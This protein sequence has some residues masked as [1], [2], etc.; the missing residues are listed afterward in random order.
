[1][2]VRA[3]NCRRDP[4]NRCAIASRFRSAMSENS[5]K[6]VRLPLY[7]FAVTCTVATGCAVWRM[8][9]RVRPRLCWV[10]ESESHRRYASRRLSGWPPAIPRGPELTGC[11]RLWKI[12]SR[13]TKLQTTLFQNCKSVKK[14]F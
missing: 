9:W 5:L 2:L 12:A 13:N 11:K 1:M 6:V 10:P 3:V 8:R 7:F 14:I 4:E